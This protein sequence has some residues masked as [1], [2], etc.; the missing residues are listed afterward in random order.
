[1][2]HVTE[3]ESKPPGLKLQ[4]LEVVLI[5]LVVLLQYLLWIAED[6][7]RQTYALRVS[8]Q[9]QAEENTVLNERN[10]ALEADITDLKNGLTAIEER[11]RTE[12][13]MIRPD[14]TFYRVLEQPLPSPSV[15]LAKPGLP[16]KPPATVKPPAPP[17]KR[18]APLIKRPATKPAT[19]AAE[20]PT[21][22]AIPD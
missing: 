19:R 3:Q 1:M 17:V 13:G 7:V 20:L 15:T 10:Q 6:G 22:D 14:E 16:P 4:I 12:M 5:T 11:A 21:D 9:A 8:I 2:A 18:P